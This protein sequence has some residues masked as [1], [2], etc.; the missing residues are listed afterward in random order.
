[1]CGTTHKTVKRVIEAHNTAA[2]AGAAGAPKAPRARNYDEVA[3]L[4]AKRVEATTGGSPRSGCCPKQP[5]RATT[6]R[7]GT[8]VDWLQMPSRHGETTTPGTAAE[9][10]R[11]GRRVRR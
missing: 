5:R 6:A 4:V 10:R 9:G 1:M 8:S 3:D 7:H 11:C 2:D